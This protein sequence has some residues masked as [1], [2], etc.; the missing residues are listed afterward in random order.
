M[1]CMER[2]IEIPTIDRSLIETLSSALNCH[3][4]LSTLLINRDITTYQTATNFLQPSL[5]NLRSPDELC[6]ISG[7]VQRISAAIEKDQKILVFGDYDVDGVTATCLLTEFLESVGARVVYYI[8]HRIHEGY[9]LNTTHIHNGAVP[10]DTELIIT[11]DCGVSSRDAVAAA[12]QKGIDVIITDHHLVT[13]PLP[14]AIAVIN[15]NR[16]DCASGLGTLSGVGV[17]FYLVIALR[18]KLRAEGHFQTVPEPN[19]KNLC[20]LVA[21]GTVADVVPLI[22]ENRIFT[23]IG[24][25]VINRGARPGLKQLIKTSRIRNGKIDSEDIA[26]RLAPRLNAAGRIKHASE[27]VEL[28]RAT[29]NDAAGQMAI[30]LDQLNSERRKIERAT[31]KDI[32][33]FFARSP[34]HLDRPAIV[35][36]SPD[37][38]PGVTGIVASRLAR[39]YHRPVLLVSM[40]SDTGK[41]SGRSVPGIDITRCLKECAPLLE[42]YGGHPAAAGLTVTSR[43]FEA[44]KALFENAV[45]KRVDRGI[46]PERFRV[47][48]ELDFA[49]IEAGLVD[50]LALVGPFGSQ[51]PEPLFVSRRVNVLSAQTVGRDHTRLTL[52]QH[53]NGRQHTVAAI[54]FNSG[55]VPDKAEQVV[56]ALRWN[57]WNGRKR[58]QA[59]VKYME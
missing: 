10:A 52:S 42:R 36:S 3:P 45:Q 23:S 7:A 55:T 35:L 54:F 51:N 19:L 22:L 56:Y 40:P 28:L 38:H 25:D 11:V 9:S 34:G 41:G 44:F 29:E 57:H 1:P 53:T 26:F 18:K 58:I 16:A 46:P 27:A 37:W 32:E 24:L 21:L 13:K 12:M 33:R 5:K 48:C 17:V 59:I 20:D 14:E 2:T 4:V 49:G 43:N 6:D 15:P 50:A 30:A 8:P 47:D 31:T 39:Q